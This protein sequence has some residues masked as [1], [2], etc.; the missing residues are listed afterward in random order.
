M[1]VIK[2]AKKRVRVANKAAIR[3]AKS[4]RI[5]K[6]ALK[7]Y[8]RSPSPENFSAAQ[9]AIDTAAKKNVIHANKAARLK[10]HMMVFAKASN[11][12]FPDK[13]ASKPAPQTAKKPSAS[14]PSAPKKPA[15]KKATTAK[16]PTSKAATKKAK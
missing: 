8:M 15:S 3:N 5:W 9:S 12:K 16:K 10:R 14:K 6:S 1:P 7:T 2:S 4:K 13:K 11:V